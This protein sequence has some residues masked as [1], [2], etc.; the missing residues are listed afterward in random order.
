MEALLESGLIVDSSFSSRVELMRDL[1][2]SGLAREIIEA[3]SISDALSQLRNVSY[4]TCIVGPSL[5]EQTALDLIHRGSEITKRKRCAF[6]AVLKP[7]TTAHER[8][9]AAGAHGTL[10]KPYS[11]NTFLQVV[12]N[13]IENSHSAFYNHRNVDLINSSRNT[14]EKLLAASLRDLAEEFD[15]IAEGISSGRFRL[16]RD[17]RPSLATRDA[18]RLALEKILP[19]PSTPTQFGTVDHAFVSFVV[20]WF[21]NRTTSD[22]RSAIDMLRDQLISFRPAPLN[23]STRPV[24]PKAV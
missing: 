8:F 7:E 23:L 14:D 5:N 2:E 3:K 11:S 17:G 16:E 4:D 12:K 1:R 15:Q 19:P 24:Y 22:E 10:S 9:R 18:I 13:A 20:Q 21:V 6:V